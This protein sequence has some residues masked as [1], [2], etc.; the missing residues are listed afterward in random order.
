[1]AKQETKSKPNKEVMAENIDEI[2]QMIVDGN[3]YKTICTKFGVPSTTL[4]AF[5]QRPEYSAR[6][7]QAR[8]QSADMIAD[9]AESILRNAEGSKE[10]LMRARELAQHYRWKAGKMN[11]KAYGDR[12][13]VEGKGL[14][15]IIKVKMT[16]RE[17][18]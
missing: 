10:E 14:T 3:T 16:G 18:T 1:M 5:L 7:R 2:I 9:L 4:F 17:Q 6:A 8:E 11:P 15:P 12:L 13:E